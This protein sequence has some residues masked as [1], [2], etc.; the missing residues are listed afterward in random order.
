VSEGEMDGVREREGRRDGG[1]VRNK[2]R[3][4]RRVRERARA[5]ES[6]TERGRKGREGE[7]E[8][9]REREIEAESEKRAT[10]REALNKKYLIM[11]TIR[12][13]VVLI[14]TNSHTAWVGC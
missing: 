8:R 10:E 6:E 14:V 4:E 2:E 1:R 13:T 12:R 7:R 5:R 3:R 11:K 9:D